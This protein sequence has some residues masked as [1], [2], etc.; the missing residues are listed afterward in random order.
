MRCQYILSLSIFSVASIANA[1]EV[2]TKMDVPRLVNCPKDVSIFV[3]RA[4]MCQ[5]FAGEINGD[6]SARDVQLS[7][8]LDKLK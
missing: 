1:C 6:H 4:L 5:H 7:E 8:Q 2:E 3:D